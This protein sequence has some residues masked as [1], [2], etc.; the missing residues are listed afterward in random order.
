MAGGSPGSVD[1]SA[2]LNGDR[3]LRREQEGQRE[4]RS[5]GLSRDTL[6]EGVKNKTGNV[7]P[8]KSETMLAFFRKAGPLI[9]SACV[10]VPSLIAGMPY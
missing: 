5:G 2:L 6:R 3:R 8:G 10:V 7:E 9:A 4:R 1:E